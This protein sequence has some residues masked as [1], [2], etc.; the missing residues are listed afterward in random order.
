M[1]TEAQIAGGHK[2]TLNN[3]NVS[4]EAK[5]HSR[6]VLENEFNGGDGE[7]SVPAG[8]PASSTVPSAHIHGHGA[9]IDVCSPQVGRQ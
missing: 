1:P 4:D 8:P 5:E 6:Q 7:F 3:P 2:A 9:D